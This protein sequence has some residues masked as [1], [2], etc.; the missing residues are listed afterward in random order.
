M[1]ASSCVPSEEYG[2]GMITTETRSGPERVDGDARDERGVDA[3]GEPEDDVL[4]AVLAS[5]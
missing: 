4:E 2:E 1:R 5:T 3:A